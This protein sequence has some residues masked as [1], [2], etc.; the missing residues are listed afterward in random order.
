M[1]NDR[2]N[3]RMLYDFDV[4]PKVF[5][6]GVESEVHIRPMGGR[7]VFIPGKSYRLDICGLN[8][9]E[10]QY[11][12][13]LADFRTRIIT[14]DDEGGFVFR[15]TFDRE[16]EY[17]LRFKEDDKF[18]YQFPVYC[19][20]GELTR[21][22]P[23]IGDTHLHTICSDGMETPEV[24][25]SNYRAYGYDFL[26]ITDHRCYAPS[27]EAIAFCRSIDTELCVCPGEE[28]QL[29]K[30][31]G[32]KND[33]HI[34]NFGGEYSVNALFP[35]EHRKKY[36]EDPKLRSLYG[37]CPETLSQ[38]QYDALMNDLC[39]KIEVPEDVDRFTA[40]NCKLVF[41]EIRKANGLGIF[42]HPNW[43]NNV[44][45][46]PEAL[47]DYLVRNR[48]FD[49][50]EVLGG[51]DY[52]EMNGFQTQRYYDDRAKGYDYPIVGATDSHSSLPVNEN[53]FLCATMVFSEKNER[54]SLISS[55]KDD[56]SAAVDT[57][58]KE[59]RMV[60]KPRLVRYATFLYKYY[61]P[62][63]DELCREEGRLMRICAAGTPDEKEEAAALLS[64]ICG[65]VSRQRAKYFAF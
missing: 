22:Y 59:F 52:Y 8:F 39:E 64:H 54:E 57:L 23:F 50:F 61:F 49:A 16:Q 44:F 15:H 62:L 58:S 32:R 3:K 28:V 20:E 47:S 29:P 46:V 51:D 43:V 11:Y 14:A 6:A 4:F 12:P 37:D 26:A 27:L 38:E 42:V 36:G 53:A 34:I 10:P 19:V 41:D 2:L 55:I 17:Y 33:V 45:H 21:R 1:A 31:N 48:L 60:G 56:Y 30:A 63:H 24:V 40:A 7:P 5:A 18:L 25:C 65:R 35:G 13:G 9:G